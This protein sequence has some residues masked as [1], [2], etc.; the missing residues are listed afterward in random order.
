VELA[1][2]MLA[3]PRRG[4]C[5]SRRHRDRRSWPEVNNPTAQDGPWVSTA[6][7]SRR[8]RNVPALLRIGT[9]TGRFP[10]I[11]RL[12]APR[13]AV[14]SQKQPRGACFSESLTFKTGAVGRLVWP[15]FS[16]VTCDVD[17]PEP[18]SL[19][20]IIKTRAV[21]DP[22]RARGAKWLCAERPR[23]VLRAEPLR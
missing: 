14:S 4:A 7:V 21:S 5:T 10:T 18:N 19:I 9:G 23:P 20:K 8:P 16:V 2:Q 12:G 6:E 3:D 17:S 11:G 15:P 13:Q 22:L 1:L